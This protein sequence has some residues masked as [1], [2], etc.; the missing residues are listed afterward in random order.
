MYKKQNMD[1]YL[2]RASRDMLDPLQRFSSYLCRCSSVFL[3]LFIF[4]YLNINK[5]NCLCT[6]THKSICLIKFFSFY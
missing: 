6:H 4:I 2:Q 1:N 3:Y 5:K